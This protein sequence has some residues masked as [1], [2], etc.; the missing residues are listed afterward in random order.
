VLREF[1]SHDGPDGA[2]ASLSWSWTRDDIWRGEHLLASRQPGTPTYHYHLDHLGTPRRITNDADQIVGIHDYHA[3]GPEAPE[4]MNEPSLSLLKF[5]AHERDLNNLPEDAATLDYMHA[6]YYSGMLGRFLSV[7]AGTDWDP[8]HPQSWNLYGYVRNNPISN[9]DPT[10]NWLT[11]VHEGL[12]DRAFPGLSEGDRAILKNASLRMDDLIGQLPM[13]AYKHSMRASDETVDQAM[14]KSAMFYD[15]KIAGAKALNEKSLA[16][17][18]DGTGRSEA[19]RMGSLQ[20]VGEAMHMVA[21]AA[22]PEHKGYQRWAPVGHPIESLQHP[23]GERKIDLITRDLVVRQLRVVYATVYGDD[24][25]A[26]AT[27]VR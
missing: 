25:L 19:L 24:A 1:T 9:V 5:T 2:L 17:Q 3:F 7:D 16:S 6:R 27:K 20:N 12:I 13:N 22:S 14:Q 10:G 8:A 26:R 11:P 18:G 21:D 4:G 23:S 15:A